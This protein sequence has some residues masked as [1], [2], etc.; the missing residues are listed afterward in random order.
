ML[1]AQSQKAD[2]YHLVSLV[3]S[4][5]GTMRLQKRVIVASY[6]AGLTGLEAI[7]GKQL[8]RSVFPSQ[9]ASTLAIG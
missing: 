8:S 3:R 1:T 9:P 4:P 2:Y 7:V 6:P 5:P